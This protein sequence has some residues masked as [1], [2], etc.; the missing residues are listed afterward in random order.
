MRARRGLLRLPQ[1]AINA[2]IR[3]AAASRRARPQLD[4]L[5]NLL[6]LQFAEKAQ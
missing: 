3:K 5:R 4:Y 6:A 2:S 1:L